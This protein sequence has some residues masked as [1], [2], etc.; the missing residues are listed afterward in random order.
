MFGLWEA[1]APSRAGTH[2]AAVSSD[3]SDVSVGSSERPEGHNAVPVSIDWRALG[4]WLREII[5][6][7]ASR[8]T[9]KGCGAG[10]GANPPK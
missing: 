2:R 9:N 6:G 10:G 1:G 5:G 4:D 7:T 3:G 8:N